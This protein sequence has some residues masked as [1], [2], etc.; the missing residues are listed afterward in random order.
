MLV[1]FTSGEHSS[2]NFFGPY[3]VD[4]D[5]YAKAVA[6]T[7]EL[8]AKE[9]AI[10]EEIKRRDKAGDVT[11]NELKTMAEEADA[12]KQ[13]RYEIWLSLKEKATPL[14]CV[15]FWQGDVY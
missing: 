13:Q 8:K 3:E 14:E 7:E 10:Y 9:L 2:Y 6:A 15:E 12:I 11:R 4:K 1:L 5:E